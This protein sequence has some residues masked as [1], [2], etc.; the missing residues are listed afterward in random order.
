MLL[1]GWR[2]SSSS[3]NTFRNLIKRNGARLSLLST[4]NLWYVCM[5][6]CACVSVRMNVCTYACVYVC[7]YGMSISRLVFK[8]KKKKKYSYHIDL[9]VHKFNRLKKKSS[10]ERAREREC[11]CEKEIYIYIYK[12]DSIVHR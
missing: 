10:Q 4:L 1:V 7:M 11:T 6:A 8:S 12:C 9:S 5:D 3:T 2:E